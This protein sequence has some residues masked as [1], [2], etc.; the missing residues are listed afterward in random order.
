MTT[1]ICHNSRARLTFDR[2][3]ES[4]FMKRQSLALIS[5]ILFAKIAATSG[6]E[7]YHL[8]K[9]I[10]L[11]G[12]GGWDYLSLDAG[13]HRLYVSHAT[14]VVVVDTE[15]DAVAGE[16]ADTPVVHG[17]AIAPELGRGIASNGREAKASIVDPK[18]LKTI[19][20]VDTGENPDAILYDT[21]HKEVYTFNGRG[22]S[23][24]VIDAQSGKVVA[25][26]PLPGKPAA[27]GAHLLLFPVKW[28]LKD[29]YPSDE[30]LK[31]YHGRLAVMLGGRDEI[32]PNELGRRLID[33]YDGP[34]KLWFEAEATHGDLHS[35]APG[36]SK[37]GRGVL[38]QREM[39]GFTL[40]V[41]RHP[42]L[43]PPSSAG[44]CR[45]R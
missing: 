14:K 20:K 26:I 18:T 37:R 29:R 15:K 44:L 7:P 21:A 6:G 13:A 23:A 8:L 38:E 41:R 11:G 24:T 39:M 9:E 17:F 3:H 16:I 34:K 30:W 35:G 33:G 36:G 10:P 43:I 12:E 2:T 31:N 22:H 40:P 5:F 1:V 32:I 28:M 25:T 4:L 27:A 45:L 19:S 42:W